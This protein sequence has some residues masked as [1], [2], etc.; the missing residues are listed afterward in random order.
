MRRVSITA[1]S[2]VSLTLLLAA[3]GS[4]SGSGSGSPPTTK[5][6]PTPNIGV[7][8]NAAK[9]FF[10]GMGGGKWT[11]GEIT[12]GLVGYASGDAQGYHCD[13][14]LSGQVFALNRVL[15]G[16]LPTGPSAST[17]QQATEVFNA[18]VHRFVPG[19][20]QWAQETTT[21]LT[22]NPSSAQSTETKV[23]NSTSVEIQASPSGAT[24][25]IEPEVIAKAQSG[26]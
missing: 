21:A 8:L 6:I 1:A 25:V 3:C 7:S 11:I 2:L 4:G 14:E 22:A 12:G 16:C 10:N 17:P 13:V 20:S 18:T 15:V 19:A 5:P 23:V 9:K 26:S 24:L